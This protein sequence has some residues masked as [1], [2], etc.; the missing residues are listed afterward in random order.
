[1]MP[2]FTGTGVGERRYL[3]EFLAEADLL[4]RQACCSSSLAC[5]HVHSVYC[6]LPH[7][8]PV[9]H[10]HPCPSRVS[11]CQV[12]WGGGPLQP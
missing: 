5:A 10:K 9:F 2:H 12:G 7:T 8:R 4:L 6:T 1:M 11:L 3:L